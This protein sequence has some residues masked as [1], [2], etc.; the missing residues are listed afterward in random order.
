MTQADNT[1][2]S[3]GRQVRYITISEVT[4]G[5]AYG[6]DTQLNTPLQVPIGLM[7]AKSAAPA[8]G[9]TWLISKQYGIWAF[10]AILNNP[11]V[12]PVII[13][14]LTVFGPPTTGR[15]IAGQLYWGQALFL[16][17]VSGTPGTWVS[18]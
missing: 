13:G 17:T 10:T 4:N 8:P 14:S 2:G 5:W 6:T 11:G 1:L 9:E 18:A 3:R 16:C 15:W 7:P 12:V